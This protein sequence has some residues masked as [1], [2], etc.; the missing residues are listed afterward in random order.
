MRRVATVTLTA[1][2]LLAVLSPASAGADVGFWRSAGLSGIDAFGVYRNRPAKVT[3]SFFLKD[4]KKDGYRPAVRFSFTERHRPDSV[5]VAAL[6]RGRVRARWRTVGSANTGH[7]Y[8]QE[9]TGRWR[10]KVF[11][12][13]KCGGWRRRY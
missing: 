1:G 4:T 8:A 10:G 2:V 9:C 6:P 5:H 12:I 13:K 3:L 7:L 11:R